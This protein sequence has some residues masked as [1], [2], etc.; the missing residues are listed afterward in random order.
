LEHSVTPGLVILSVSE[1]SLRFVLQE[2]KKC[3]DSSL[4]LGMTG[5]RLR[6]HL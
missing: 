6:S 3:R 2:C 4:A 5:L 1:E